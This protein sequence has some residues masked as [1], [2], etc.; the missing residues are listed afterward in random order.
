MSLISALIIF[1]S[2]FLSSYSEAPTEAPVQ[3]IEAPAE[4]PVTA[5]VGD[6]HEAP[7]D[8]VGQSLWEADIELSPNVIVALTNDLNCGAEASP[9]GLG[10]CTY[11]LDNG[12]YYVTVSPELAWTPQGTHI[13][14]HE[15]G[16]TLGMDECEA[17][18]YAAQ[19]DTVEQWSYPE[20]EETQ[21]H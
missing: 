13:L 9:V 5:Y 20:C 19:F 8:W 11:T 14:F 1:L 15:I 6:I 3:A 16:H 4:A 10:G 18:Y 2:A 12:R 7:T 21:H 17:E